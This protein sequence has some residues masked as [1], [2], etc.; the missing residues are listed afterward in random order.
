MA[1][2][3]EVLAHQQWIGILQPEGLVVSAPVLHA[4]GVIL[5]GAPAQR[6]L[7]ERLE[8]CICKTTDDDAVTWELPDFE[9][10]A[11]DFL[12]WPMQS[13]AW[14][15]G[16]LKVPVELHSN[17]EAYQ[18]QLKPTHILYQD[19]KPLILIMEIKDCL[20]FT[21]KSDGDEWDASPVQRMERLLRDKRISIGILHSKHEVRLVYAPPAENS[22]SIGFP[23]SEMRDVPGRPIVAALDCLLSK[24]RVLGPGISSIY[25]LPALLVASRES[26][27]SV[28]DKL[29]EQV[30][31][32]LYELI[33][34]LQQAD[35]NVKQRLLGEVLN[36]KPEEIYHALLTLIMRLIFL[37]YAE[38]KGVMPESDLYF[39]GY[40]AKGLFLRLQDDFQRHGGNMDKRYGAWAQ[41]LTTFRLVYSGCAHPQMRMPERL[42]YLFDPSRYPFLN[43][44][45]DGKMPL[46]S[47]AVI[48]RVLRLLL[49]IDGERLSYR[50]LDVE[51]IGAVYE[52]M[53]GFSVY[54]S[55]GSTVLIGGGSAPAAVELEAL[56]EV[57]AS[58]RVG[59]LEEW[60]GYKASAKNAKAIKEAKDVAELESALSGV[61]R[62][63]LTPKALAKGAI[64]LN[65]GEERRRSGSHYTPRE[66]TRPLVAKA[67]EPHFNRLGEKPRAKDILT[68]TICDPA[69]GSGAFLVEACRQ[70]SVKLV[71][72]WD[73]YPEDKPPVSE[74]DSIEF[75]ALRTVAQ[76]CI[77]GVDRNSMAVDLAKMSMWLLTIS[78]DHPFTFMDHSLRHGDALVGMS[79]EQIKKFHWDLSK[80]S[81]I[82]QTLTDLDREVDDAVK[83]RLELRNLDADRTLDLEVK[84]AEADEKMRKAKLAGDLLVYAWFSNDKDKTRT[85][86]RDRYAVQLADVL[87]PDS[88]ERKAINNLR[89]ANKAL[90][91]FHWELEFPEVFADGGFAVFVGNPPFA[92]KNTMSAG[93][94]LNYGEYLT[95]VLSPGASGMSD[96]VAHFF[97]QTFNFLRKQGATGCGS[98][99][100]IS[101]KTIRQGHTRESSLE[102]I[103]KAGG[104]I[105]YA[106]RRLVWP[107]KAAVLIA[108]I[109]ISK[110]QTEVISELDGKPVKQISSFLVDT[111]LD[112]TPV[113]LTCN[114]GK[115]F[116]G[117]IVLGMGFT[118]DDNNPDATPL[119]KMREILN[120]C[121]ESQQFIKI[122][123][124]GEQINNQPEFQPV[125]YA[126]DFG[127]MKEDEAKKHKELYDILFLKVKPERFLVK[128]G[129]SIEQKRKKYPRMVDEWW[130]YWNARTELYA[131]ISK[132]PRVL[133][134][135]R[136]AAKY[137]TFSFI[138]AG[139]VYADR[140][141]VF[142]DFTYSHFAIVQSRVHE[143][144][145]R[146]FGTSLG[147]QMTYTGT[148][149]YENFPFPPY[150][151]EL[152]TL[153]KLY[154]DTR[155]NL[156]KE[157]GLGLTPLGNRLNDKD[158]TLP[159]LLK[160]RQLHADMDN[161]VLKAYGWNDIESAYEFIGDYVN[162]DGTLG[163]VRLSFIEEVRDEIFRRLIVL[164][165]ER[166]K[167]E[168]AQ[169]NLEF[170]KI[171]KPKPKKP[172]PPSDAGQSELF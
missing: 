6:D 158:E 101:T 155:A 153:G 9:L 152:E 157:L 62:R 71:K 51:N 149:C 98:L 3:P 16:E 11:R 48:Y 169:P 58:D 52:T 67:F 23:V 123:V 94:I 140:L 49:I 7:Q 116:Q 168:H 132:N 145:A 78:K 28:S 133:V 103:R 24:E 93:N 42:G 111:K 129:D 162:D 32:A 61:I 109:A 54:Q 36:Q 117:S 90:V 110:K 38:D 139:C 137:L 65:P 84:L 69:M 148:K 73:D 165:A 136:A 141:Y 44:D 92:G 170:K 112:E 91:P 55:Q 122:Y 106:N 171:S 14:E 22:G 34:G 68:M 127:E 21:A 40:S 161:A 43:A 8:K 1:I 119:I 46:V 130:K 47:D 13:I 53:M 99:C 86:A 113:S 31:G 33:K 108:I 95:S 59:K 163:D 146:M 126:I 64:T 120:K 138:P 76:R 83:A 12:G 118:F 85:E 20:D 2:A 100:M 89:Y 102:P 151:D 17:V 30:L 147:D 79:K 125:R 75:V 63:D 80:G 107:G 4:S 74:G 156:M 41:L 25:R 144:W 77:Y 88:K 159:N 18:L 27:N 56:F 5:P 135:N 82:I 37:L 15:H 39:R 81:G 121:P 114:S 164:H 87:L 97:N 45:A 131:A 160:L 96:L 128:K 115:S 104:I 19:S 105:Y 57:K 66:L 134:A 150:T 166:L 60:T 154:N 124:G 26:Q 10:F 50:S 72:A 35:Q 70:L 172:K 167:A 142:S 29:A 143:L